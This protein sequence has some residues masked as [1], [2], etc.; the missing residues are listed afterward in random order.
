MED[1]CTGYTL[2]AGMGDDKKTYLIDMAGMIVHT[3]PIGGMP[4]KMLSNGHLIGAKS[5]R[6]GKNPFIQDPRPK[7]PLDFAPWHDNIELVELDWDGN[8]IWSFSNYDDDATGIIMSRQHHDFQRQGNPVGYYAPGQNFLEN[9]NTLILAHLNKQISHISNKRLVDDTLYEVDAK[10]R[11]TG[12]EWHCADRFD[13]FGFDDAQKAELYEAGN[14]DAEKNR[15]DWIHINCASYLGKNHLFEELD[16]HRFHPDNIII[17]ARNTNFIAII[18]KSTSRVV[19]KAGP[20]FTEEHPENK[21]GQIIGQHHV[22]MIPSGL[23]GAGNILL[24]DNGGMPE[25]RGNKTSVFPNNRGYS[26]VIE[27][28]PLTYKIIWK[29]GAKEGAE[30]FFSHFIS[31]AQ[32]L[33]NGNTLITAGAYGHIFEVTPSKDVV[34]EFQNPRGK[35]HEARIYRAYRIPPEWT[36]DNLRNYPEWGS[37][38]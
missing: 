8:E 31:S 27:I 5:D 3:W 32:R 28:N 18:D 20:H 4:V 19:W 35:C 21:M 12:F 16:D 17:S 2:Y 24:F 23:P 11:Q 25:H 36:P 26:R 29:Y 33:P 37:T 38:Y 22:H 7:N 1:A 13:E 6:G 9:G 34:W 15:S 14:F 30:F 10:G